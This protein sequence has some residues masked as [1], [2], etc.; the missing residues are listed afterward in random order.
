[1]EVDGDKQVAR[2]QWR[3]HRFDAPRVAPSLEVA[4]EVNFKALAVQM[5]RC[6]GFGVRMGMGDE[7]ARLQFGCHATLSIARS[8]RNPS[9][10]GTNTRSA[11]SAAS[12]A[13]TLSR[14]DA[15]SAI[16][17]ASN[18]PVTASSEATTGVPT[19]RSCL[20]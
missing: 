8:G 15:R 18:P 7:P 1:M 20:A 16:T 13:V 6:F 11:S 12:V 4:R 19:K 17:T 5:R 2:E 9:K 3:H 14:V 10:A